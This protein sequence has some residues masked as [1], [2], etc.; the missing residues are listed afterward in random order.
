MSNLRR[1]RVT[2]VVPTRNCKDT[3]VKL[4]HS[5]RKL[6]YPNYEVLIVD[7]STDGTDKICKEYRFKVILFSSQVTVDTNIKRNIGIKNAS[8]D[9]IAFTD[10]DCEVPS[11]WLSEIA[12]T[13]A[14][15]PNV[16]IVGGSVHTI[17]HSFA[18]YYADE[19]LISILPKY[20]YPV[21]IRKSS[22]GIRYPVCCNIAFRRS[23]F[24]QNKFNENWGHGWDE[25]ELLC[26]LTNQGHLI[27]INPKIIVHHHHRSSL[28]KLLQQV[29]HYGVGAEHFAQVFKVSLFKTIR[30]DTHLVA[31][32]S[33][34]YAIR[35]ACKKRRMS[36]LLYPFIDFLV[37]ISYFSGA[38]HQYIKKEG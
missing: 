2:V 29:Y 25:I 38:F 28:T 14:K 9:I 12:S 33:L 7:S 15:F 34:P 24:E 37:C 13:F 22:T 8:G 27:Y 6:D 36:P 1:P 17:P 11:N 20:T 35:L 18:E 4:L 10:G 21:L 26:Q 5:L 32:K 3:I 19:A 31:L 23:I 16:D 30:N